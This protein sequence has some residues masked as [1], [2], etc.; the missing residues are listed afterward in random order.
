[1]GKTIRINEKQLRNIISCNL[2]NSTKNNHLDLVYGRNVANN[3]K[4]LPLNEISMNRLLGK[5]YGQ[6]GFAIVSAS[7]MVENTP[8]ENESNTKE[9]FAAIRNSEFRFIPA[10]GGYIEKDENGN[11]VNNTEEK[12]AIILCYDQNSNPI[13]FERLADFAIGLGIKYNQDSV[14]LKAPDENPKYVVTNERGGEVGTTE[15]EFTGDLRLDD[16]SQ[17][18]FTN[19]ASK[20]GN[21]GQHRFTFTEQFINPTFTTV[22]EGHVRYLNGELFL[23][24]GEV[25]DLI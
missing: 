4:M 16:L 10:F 12:V 17:E 20:H 25:R 21:V 3:Q 1:M 13:P 9:M 18:F 6:A 24:P 7:R 23:K 15:M 14:L 19:M 11:A 22:N 2:Q 8:E 5:H